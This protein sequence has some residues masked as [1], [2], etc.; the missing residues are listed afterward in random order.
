M[1]F[2]LAS[3]STSELFGASIEPSLPSTIAPEIGII[4][5]SSESLK[6]LVDE[7]RATATQLKVVE[8][9]ISTLF[10]KI[11]LGVKTRFE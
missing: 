2:S 9:E 8:I 1:T 6:S 10:R 7:Q 5:L 11:R 4:M 3:S